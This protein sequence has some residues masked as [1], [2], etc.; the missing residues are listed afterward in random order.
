MIKKGTDKYTNKITG[1][2]SLYEIQ[3]KMICAELFISLGVY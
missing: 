3:K 1:S 2:A